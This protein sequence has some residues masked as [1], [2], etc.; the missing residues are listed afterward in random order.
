[1]HLLVMAA[2]AAAMMGGNPELRATTPK[3]KVAA[4]RQVPAPI[5]SF[6]GD[7]TASTTTRTELNGE[8]CRDEGSNLKCAAYLD[9]EVAGV[10]MGF[11]TLD[12][13]NRLL[14]RVAGSFYSR[15]YQTIHAAFTEKYGLAKTS[16]EKWQAKNGGTF[17]N[18]VS[19]WD[20]DGGQLKL[21]SMGLEIGKSLFTFVSVKNAPPVEKPKIDF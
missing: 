20:F 2:L 5:F 13:H 14:Y 9:A 6:M 17:D 12:Y 21:E 16:V 3:P 8:R 7:T 15:N 4:T 18:A 19:V 1:M 11:L 10:K